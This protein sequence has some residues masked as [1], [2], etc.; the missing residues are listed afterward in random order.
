MLF[1]GGFKNLKIEG[2]LGVYDFEKEG[3]RTYFVSI[4]YLYNAQKAAETDDIKYAVDYAEIAALLN[5]KAHEKHYHLIET[6]AQAF[7]TEIRKNF[8]VIDLVVR[9]D[10][11]SPLE[12]ME[13]SFVELG[14]KS[15][16]RSSF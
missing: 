5:K 15:I 9:V 2:G 3:P 16:A 6:L 11:P 7:Y 10:K 8:K 12:G 4:S 13:A 1:R 14:K